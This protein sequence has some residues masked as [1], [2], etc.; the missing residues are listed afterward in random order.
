MRTP[1]GPGQDAGE[2]PVDLGPARAQLEADEVSALASGI[3][4]AVQA[5][6]ALGVNVA[7]HRVEVTD[8]RVS[9][10]DTE[11]AAVA[12]AAAAATFDAFGCGD[13][14]RVTFDSGWRCHL[15]DK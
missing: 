15:I 5:L 4:H 12:A 13:R 10:A 2:G 11:P 6:K 3:A 1:A 14:V 7:G 8:V 9:L